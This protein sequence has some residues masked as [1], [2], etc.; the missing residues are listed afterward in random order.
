MREEFPEV[1]NLPWDERY[2]Q[3]LERATWGSLRRMV[4]RFCKLADS[5]AVSCVKFQIGADTYPFGWSVRASVALR[6]SRVIRHGHGH[7]R[8]RAR[9]PLRARPLAQA[10]LT[11]GIQTVGT[12]Q[13]PPVTLAK[14]IRTTSQG[15]LT[16]RI[17]ASENRCNIASSLRSPIGLICLW[18][19]VTS[20]LFSQPTHFPENQPANRPGCSGSGYGSSGQAGSCSSPNTTSPVRTSNRFT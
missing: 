2:R 13:S 20:M 6:G 1:K 7:G 11:S 17:P 14:A 9:R 5:V 16:C 4:F 18:K 12:S 19:A 15:Y 3:L 8:L 10:V